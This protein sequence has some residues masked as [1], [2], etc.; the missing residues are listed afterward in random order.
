MVLKT[1]FF[2]FWDQISPL[3][4]CG[5]YNYLLRASNGPGRHYAGCFHLEYSHL[6]LA[7]HAFE[8]GS[9]II[10]VLQMRKSWLREVQWLIQGHPAVGLQSITGCHHADSASPRE[11]CPSS[12]TAWWRAAGVAS[13][14][15]WAHGW[16][17]S[18]GVP[19]Q[20]AVWPWA[21]HVP[22]WGRLPGRSQSL[23]P[24]L[25]TKTLSEPKA[26]NIPL[27]CSSCLQSLLQTP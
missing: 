26:A 10:I 7:A 1:Q 20:W 23:L 15:A 25:V 2:T 21:S 16:E 5:V 6:N 9:W 14:N 17:F 12:L 27:G 19:V 4:L 11:P 8:E 13:R 18:L 22:L 3:P 24:T